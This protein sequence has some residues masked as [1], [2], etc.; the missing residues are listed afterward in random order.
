MIFLNRDQCQVKTNS[1]KNIYLKTNHYYR[2]QQSLNRTKIILNDFN[3][4]F[5]NLSKKGRHTQKVPYKF[6]HSQTG[7]DYNRKLIQFIHSSTKKNNLSHVPKNNHIFVTQKPTIP[8]DNV[9]LLLNFDGGNFIRSDKDM[10][11]I[12]IPVTKI[13][14]FTK[15]LNINLSKAIGNF[16]SF[17]R[18]KKFRES[19]NTKIMFNNNIDFDRYL[20]TKNRENSDI[21]RTK[22]K[23]SISHFQNKLSNLAKNIFNLK[24]TNQ[25]NYKYSLFINQ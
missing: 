2:N 9:Q 14:N 10:K 7:A 17:S 1:R 18:L 21:F 24:I 20:I 4:S 3:K 8:R 23:P 6:E 19:K 25:N 11:I 5:P 12:K 15:S 16:G 13:N 22:L